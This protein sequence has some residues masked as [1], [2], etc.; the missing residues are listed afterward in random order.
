MFVIAEFVISVRSIIMSKFFLFLLFGLLAVIL[1]YIV[2][3]LVVAFGFIW[4]DPHNIARRADA[5][6]LAYSKSLVAPSDYDFCVWD[7]SAE[8]VLEREIAR[9]SSI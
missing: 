4:Y 6:R 5:R 2:F 3:F 1:L 9:R 8:G 7:G